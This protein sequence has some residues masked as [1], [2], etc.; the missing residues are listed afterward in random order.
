MLDS[1][2]GGRLLGDFLDPTSI[3]DEGNLGGRVLHCDEEIRW[4]EDLPMG[5]AHVSHRIR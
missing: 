3:P 4:L 5:L 2:I 1:D